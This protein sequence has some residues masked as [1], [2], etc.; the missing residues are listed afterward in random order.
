MSV[1]NKARPQ[2]RTD[3]LTVFHTQPSTAAVSWVASPRPCSPST[4]LIL[5]YCNFWTNGEEVPYGS[6]RAGRAADLSSDLGEFVDVQLPHPYSFRLPVIAALLGARRTP[7]RL[8][9]T[10]LTTVSFQSVSSSG[11]P[12]KRVNPRRHR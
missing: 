1:S 12:P 5:H 7:C 9:R 11:L 8:S 10:Q 6:A 4:Q 2:R 3:A